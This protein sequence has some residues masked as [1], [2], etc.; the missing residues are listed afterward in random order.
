MH[1]KLL[2][3]KN[4]ISAFIL[5]NWK[6]HQTECYIIKHCRRACYNLWRCLHGLVINYYFSLFSKI[7]S[8]VPMSIC[9]Q[10][11]CFTNVYHLMHCFYDGHLFFYIFY[12]GHFFSPLLEESSSWSHMP[13][14]PLPRSQITLKNLGNPYN[15]TKTTFPAD[16]L[17]TNLWYHKKYIGL[18]ICWPYIL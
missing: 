2:C 7:L 9:L 12:D 15:L 18:E 10:W 16:F 14:G 8:F 11:S 5:F 1:L 13:T 6:L 4:L 17:I 3:S